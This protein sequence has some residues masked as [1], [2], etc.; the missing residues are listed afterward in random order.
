MPSS[1]RH[2]NE[3]GPSRSPRATRGATRSCQDD[4]T[5][6]R[7]LAAVVDAW[8]ELPEAIK[9]VIVAMVRTARSG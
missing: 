1:C 6:D 5:N 7:D 3:T 4:V 9:A 2:P 8:H